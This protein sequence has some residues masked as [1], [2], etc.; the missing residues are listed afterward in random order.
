MDNFLTASF[1]LFVM[2]SR[3]IIKL[4]NKIYNKYRV[5]ENIRLHMFRVASVGEFLCDK[6][7]INGNEKFDIIA[8]LLLHDIGN[9]AKI[10]FGDNFN[11][12]I[13]GNQCNRL[14]KIKKEIIKKYG[15]S[16]KEIWLN[17]AKELDVNNKILGYMKLGFDSN[18]FSVVL[19]NYADAR[20]SPEGICSLEY[21][22]EDAK[23]RYPYFF[24]N[25]RRGLKRIERLYEMEEEIMKKAKI[26]P[27]DINEES[28]EIYMKK[29]GF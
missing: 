15:S 21:R 17:I 2:E 13:F 11:K 20:V 22:I 18:V 10:D 19:C 24:K 9:I 3:E 7:G 14:Q 23:R 26:N 29:Y 12:E 28:V 16:P 6:V 4:I 27:E 1:Y 5:L 25:K 8:L